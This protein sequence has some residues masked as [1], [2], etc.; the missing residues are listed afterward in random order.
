MT[1]PVWVEQTDGKFTAS[2]LGATPLEATRDTREEAVHAVSQLVQISIRRGAL[3]FVDVPN[4]PVREV[5]RRETTAEELE[6]TREMLAEAYR[7]RDE[8]KTLEFP[9]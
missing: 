2:V 1:I 7:Q 5:S 3:V 4:V 6:A 8:E 9:G